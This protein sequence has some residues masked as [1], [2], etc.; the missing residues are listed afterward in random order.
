MS[1]QRP[2]M[3]LILS[4]QQTRSAA[5]CSGNPW[6]QTPHLDRLA[7]AGTRFDLAYCAAPVCGPSRASLFTG[8]MPHEHG[9]TLNSGPLPEGM[10]T[11]G[12]AFAAA[13]Y[14]SHYIGKWHVPHCFPQETDAIPGFRNHPVPNHP[15]GVVTDPEIVKQAVEFLATPQDRPFLL[16]VSLQ[17]PHDICHWIMKDRMEW[18][19]HFSPGPDDPLPP[20]PENF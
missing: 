3:V 2:N 6:V 14:D 4:D 9:V 18:L 12:S 7:V 8:R 16:V 17:N 20:L 5:S 10:P 13:G 1:L 19:D 15:L 11:L